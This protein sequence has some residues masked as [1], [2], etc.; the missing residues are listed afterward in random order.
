MND[1]LVQAPVSRSRLKLAAVGLLAAALFSALAIW[2]GVPAQRQV[3]FAVGVLIL[4]AA[5]LAFGAAGWYLLL[6]PAQEPIA[7]G[8][9]LSVPTRRLL[10]ALLLIG[11]LNLVVGGFWDEVWHRRYGIPFGE[12]F[13]WRPHLLIY[14]A[15]AIMG[16]LALSGLV[17]LARRGRGSLPARFQAEPAAGLLV[18]VG[19][20]ML[21]ALPAD[22][23]WHQIYG[24]DISA[25]S[26]PHLLVAFTFALTMILAAAIQLSTLPASGAASGL[27]P[28]ELPA[29]LSLAFVL[30]IGLQAMTTDWEGSQG[31]FLGRPE[32]LLPAT[33]AGLAVFVGAL[34]K[35]SLR[36]TATGRAGAASRSGAATLTGLTALAIRLGLL[37][38][39]DAPNITTKAWLLA[40][41][42]LLALDLAGWFT[43]LR[44]RP[45][46]RVVAT[47]WAAGLA[48]AAS[49]TVAG[50]PLLNRFYAYPQITL[51]NLPEMVMAV[52]VAAVGAAWAGQAAGDFIAARKYGMEERIATGHWQLLPPL[53]LLGSVVFLVWFIATARPPV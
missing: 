23:L 20:F 12:D 40:L 27:R 17:V 3:A 33:I 39:F 36:R 15:I 10:A 5:L 50:F 47:P 8:G 42:P 43:Q 2:G 9:L 46:P 24:Q 45:W 35:A 51:A 30:L 52:A 11:G 4:L 21:L 38:L 22:P 6:R 26:I 16:L 49:M 41:L 14:S 19:A 13:F 53:A 31:P 48:A 25:A 32:W 34:A 7:A 1:A 37:T 44:R 28:A 29:I 18:L